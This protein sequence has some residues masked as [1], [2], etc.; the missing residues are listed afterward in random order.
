MTKVNELKK[1]G[2]KFMLR[3]SHERMSSGISLRTHCFTRSNYWMK[4]CIISVA[5]HMTSLKFK[6]KSYPSYQDFT[7]TMH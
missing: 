4:L 1:V 2:L 7:F 6:L 3:F 5:F